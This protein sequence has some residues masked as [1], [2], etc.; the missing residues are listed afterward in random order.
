MGEKSWWDLW[1]ASYRS[2][3]NG[4]EISN[5]L[6]A[7]TSTI[8]NDLTRSEGGR[9]LEVACGTGRLSRSLAFSSYQ[10]LDIS[11]TAIEIARQKGERIQLPVGMSRPTYEAAD[12]HDWPLPSEPF[13]VALCVDAI[14]C[15]RDQPLVLKKIARSLRPSGWLVLTTINPFVYWRIKRTWE[16]GP[17]SHWLSRRELHTMVKSAGIDIKRSF[18]IMPRGNHGIL[19][20]INSRKLNRA[21]GRRNEAAVRRLKEQAGFGQYRVVIGRKPE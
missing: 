2:E 6:F 16:N 21:L 7:R 15:F 18:T 17:V 14:S 9:I 12:F 10:G 11:P 3:D 13:D 5:E 4:D 1:N 8:V 20:L 19:R